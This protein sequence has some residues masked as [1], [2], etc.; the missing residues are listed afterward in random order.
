[1]TVVPS[2][3]NQPSVI[4]IPQV[5]YDSQKSVVAIALGSNLNNPQGQLEMGLARLHQHPCIDVLQVSPC[6]WTEPVVWLETDNLGC[7]T[8]QYPAVPISDTV[9][10][11]YLNGAA[12]LA[13]TLCPPQLM[14][15]LLD[16]ETQQGR[17]RHGKW[18][19]RTLDLDILLWES[20][21]L[22]IPA[23]ELTQGQLTNEV[24]LPEVIVPHPRMSE[25]PFVL[26][27]L[28]ALVPDWIVPKPNNAGVSVRE[29]AVVAGTSGVE[30]GTPVTIVSP[31]AESLP[32]TA[33]H[34]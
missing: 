23:S 21:R 10:P 15:I 11:P 9:L 2:D 33:Q 13:T 1:M 25:R 18:A 4:R 16:V 24:P 26:V 5:G 14:Q 17:T 6:F 8:T 31:A 27:P 29:L 22:N 30:L 20:A 3:S 7:G 28:N 34:M 12:L 32:E 19:A